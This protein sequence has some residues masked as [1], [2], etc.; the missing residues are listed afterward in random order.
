MDIVG[1]AVGDAVGSEVVGEVVGDAVGKEVVGAVVGKDVVGANVGAVGDRVGVVVGADVVG[2]MVGSEVVGEVVGD[3]VGPVVGTE[4]GGT[5][6]ILHVRGQSCRI[7]AWIADDWQYEKTSWQKSAPP[8]TGSVESTHA[9]GEAVGAT[10]H[11]PQ[12][13]GQSSETCGLKELTHCPFSARWAHENPV[14]EMPSSQG[15]KGS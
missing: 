10:E 9:N 5:V 14:A 13:R 8:S 7:R 11:S 15:D 4:V 6:Q 1:D 12:V 3:A 2:E